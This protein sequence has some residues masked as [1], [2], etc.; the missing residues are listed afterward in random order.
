MNQPSAGPRPPMFYVT[1]V[2]TA[3]FAC[4]ALWGILCMVGL[5]QFASLLGVGNAFNTSGWALALLLAVARFRGWNDADFPIELVLPLLMVAVGDWE[6]IVYKIHTPTVDELL[7]AFDKIYGYPEFLL[8]RMFY[9]ARPVLWLG[10]A[11]YFALMLPIVVVHVALKDN[12][13]RIRLWSAV[14]LMGVLGVIFYYVCPAAGP[15]YVFKNYPQM[16]VVTAPA[17][18]MIPHLVPNCTPSVHL[19]MALLALFFA[20]RCARWCRNF[21]L[22]F[23][24]ATVL[25][26]LGLGEHYVIDLVLGV[27][28]AVAIEGMTYREGRR[29]AYAC[30]LLVLAWEIALDKGW[31]LRLPAPAALLLSCLTVA[32]PL[33]GMARVPRRSAG[34]AEEARREEENATRD[35]CETVE[36]GLQI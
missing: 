32:A 18:R 31:A 14:A 12:K 34:G 9:G 30:F 25:V 26:T 10:K 1:L 35:R 27:P 11:V 33:A 6:G 2:M 16:P 7:F 17:A 23:L 3:F 5:P 13:L 36:S 8:G 21:G 29:R 22:A 28:F 19:A 15:I 20:W 24:G 4:F